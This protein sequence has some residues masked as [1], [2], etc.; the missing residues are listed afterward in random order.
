MEKSRTTREE[1]VMKRT[2]VLL[3]LNEI[4]G[5]TAL[6]D[7]IPF[8]AA[9]ESLVVD[10]GS[11]DGTVEFFTSRGVRVVGQEKKGRGEAFRVAFDSSA[12]DVLCFFSP[13]GNEDPADVPRLFEKIES[14]ADMA[15][16][17]RFGEGARNEEDDLALRW[18]A[19][20]NQAFTLLANLAFN[21]PN[22]LRDRGA[23]VQ[24]TINGYRAIT[25]DAFQ[26]LSVDAEGF[27]IEYQMTMRALKLG[28]KVAEIP[29]IEHER[30]GGQS[31]ASSLPTG[32]RFVRGLTREILI[33][34]RF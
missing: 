2:L 14:G 1:D 4:E 33:G 18:R 23:Y 15:I 16:A 7:R 10:G 6:F 3:T 21:L 8:D 22:V 17:R 20:A 32:L 11:K 31:T 19:W 25:R 27:L 24:D 26:R 9:D 29:T 5:V 34:R 30:I 28:M 13:D 12:G